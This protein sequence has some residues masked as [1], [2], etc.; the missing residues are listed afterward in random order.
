MFA[1]VKVS[2]LRQVQS[3][4]LSKQELAAIDIARQGLVDSH[5][6]Y[7]QLLDDF[8]LAEIKAI[9]GALPK[10]CLLTPRDQVFNLPESAPELQECVGHNQLTE[11]VLDKEIVELSIK[12]SQSVAHSVEL[13]MSVKLRNG[14]KGH[15]VHANT[16]NPG[17]REYQSRFSLYLIDAD[18]KQHRGSYSQI[19]QLFPDEA[20]KPEDLYKEG[21]YCYYG[22]NKSINKISV[23]TLP[24]IVAVRV[25]EGES[26]TK[27][28]LTLNDGVG[29]FEISAKEVRH[30]FTA[31]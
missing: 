9:K 18:G 10:A 6:K 19:A 27:I 1:E 31:E 5:S 28:F 25:N 26:L 2:D 7:S 12:G 21:Q 8:E 20:V 30:V 22:N 29:K 11:A 24:T 17:S 4:R 15:I 3:L 13:G 16:I 14:L 23:A